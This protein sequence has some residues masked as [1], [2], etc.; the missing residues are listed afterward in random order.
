MEEV[1]KQ[2]AKSVALQLRETDGESAVEAE[3]TQRRSSVL[4]I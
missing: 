3:A 4:W 2:P 1:L